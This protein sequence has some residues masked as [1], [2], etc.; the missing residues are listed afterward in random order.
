MH[1]SS[2][3]TARS[4]LYRGSLSRKGLCQGG[5]G[6]LSRRGLCPGGGG[7]CPGGGGL[8]PG[9]GGLCPGGLCPDHQK[10]HGTG[11]PDRK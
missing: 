3:C 2:M 6:S 7:L 9:S 5:G 1:S 4:L 8:C 11:Q 10:E